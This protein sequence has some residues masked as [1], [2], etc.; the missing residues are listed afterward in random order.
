VMP[1]PDDVGG[2]HTL[3]AS[4]DA[5]A[6]AQAQYTVTPSVDSVSPQIVK[7]GQ[8]ITVHLKGVGY[9]QTANIYTLVLDNNYLGYACGA[10]SRGDVTIHMFAPGGA[11]V[12][13]V[14]LYP[15][16][17]EGQIFGPSSAQK[18]NSANV[19][20]FQIPMLNFVDHPGER[21][22]AFHLTFEVQ[23]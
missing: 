17:Y 8:R 11:G 19:S 16:I 7:P 12:H 22:P 21:L 18:T 15:A 5:G 1:T 9:T 14:D 2:S 10:N 20:Y 3:T 4:T 23:G 13:F 6:S